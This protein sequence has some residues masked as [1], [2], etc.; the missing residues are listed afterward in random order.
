MDLPRRTSLDLILR[1][2]GALPQPFVPSYTELDV[3]FGWRPTES[4][5]I[6][7]VGQ[8]LLDRQHLEF[9]SA[10]AATAEIERSFYGKVTWRF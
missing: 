1:H 7:L 4:V 3:Q 8:N 9:G 10:S 5:E 2:V 6:S